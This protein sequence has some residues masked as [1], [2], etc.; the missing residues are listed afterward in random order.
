MLNAARYCY[1]GANIYGEALREMIRG[2]LNQSDDRLMD[3]ISKN[4]LIPPAA[5]TL[6][7]ELDQPSTDPSKGQSAVVK[8]IFVSYLSCHYN[9][10]ACSVNDHESWKF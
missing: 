6:P 7:Y 2:P 4:Y 10:E 8:K 9:M 1:S 5:K 3:L